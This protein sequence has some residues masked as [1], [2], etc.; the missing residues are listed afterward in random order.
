MCKPSIDEIKQR[1]KRYPAIRLETENM[2][3]RL[4]MLKSE[5][6]IPP[7]RQGDGS[8]RTAGTGDRQERA[9]LRRMEYEERTA[10]TIAANKQEIKAIDAAVLALSDPLEREVITIHYIEV[11]GYKPIPWRDVAIAMYGD[12]AEAD[13]LRVHRLHGKALRSLQEIMQEE[14]CKE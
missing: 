12:D 3:S 11:D 14:E 8:K 10:P 5:E 7:V 2:I 1:L 6:T 4:E 9:I 13:V